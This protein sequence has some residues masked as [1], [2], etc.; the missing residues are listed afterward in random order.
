MTPARSMLTHLHRFHDL[1]LSL[2]NICVLYHLAD[3]PSQNTVADI[4]QAIGLR[5]NNGNL[6][7]GLIQMIEQGIITRTSTT[8]RHNQPLHHHRLSP[9][10]YKLL[11]LPT[12][13]QEPETRNPTHETR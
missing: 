5:I 11:R 10:G 9:T 1:N 3:K 2:R 13:N 4:A 8:N 12:R 6:R 7:S